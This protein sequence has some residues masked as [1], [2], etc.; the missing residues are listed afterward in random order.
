MNYKGLKY[1][2]FLITFLLVQLSV[3]AQIYTAY[4]RIDTNAIKI[5]EQILLQIELRAPS[6]VDKKR[7][8]ELNW[9]DLKDTITSK[10]VILEKF[11]PD[12]S[13]SI[14]KKTILI[15]QKLLITS[16]DTGFVV[17]PPLKFSKQNDSLFSIETQAL[18][19][20][21]KG[22]Q[23]DENADIKEIKPPIE[24]G[25][26]LAE[27]LIFLA[28]LYAIGAIFGLVFWYLKK[29]KERNAYTE[30]ADN[31]PEIILPPHALALAKLE[32]LRAKEVWQKGNY[33]TYHSEVSEIIRTYLEHRFLFPALESSSYDILKSVRTIEMSDENR[34]QLKQ[35]LNLTDL[36]KFAKFE[37]SEGENDMVM[38]VAK[39]FV[40]QTAPKMTNLDEKDNDSEKEVNHV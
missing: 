14:D 18:L 5:G 11:T 39:L 36:V 13:I 22:V 10:L 38:Q 37:P 31:E 4:A 30:T 28:I 6:S 33:K 16:Y 17:I 26:T 24:V 32:E 20:N 9:P 7:L 19:I 12:T 2:F 27:I 23:V 15:R 34:V 29:L 25:Y 8:A 1:Y 21:V 35:L 3:K 40:M